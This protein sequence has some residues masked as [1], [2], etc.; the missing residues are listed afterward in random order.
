MPETA[1]ELYYHISTY[2][3]NQK[4]LLQTPAPLSKHSRPETEGAKMLI[5]AVLHE[6]RKV[7]SEM[8]SKAILRAFRIPV[9]QTMVAHTPTESLLLAE[10]I[11]FPIAMKIDSPDIVHKSE[12][13]G[14]RL[15]ITNAPAVRNA[16]HDIIETVKKRHPTARINGV[17]IE[18][19]LARPNGRELMIGV[20]RDPI[21][22]PIITFGA[23]GT[24]VEVFSDRAVALPPLNRFLAR[25]LIRSTRASK[26]LGEFRNMPPVNLEALEDV[27]LHVSQM[28]CELPWLQELDLNPLI[29][30]E[31]GAIAADARIV[32]DYAAPS[33][34]RYAH[35]AIHPYPVHLIQEWELPD[36]RTVTIRPIRPEDAEREQQFVIGLSD[37]SKYYRFMDTIRELTQTM[38]VRF[39][40]I[41]YDREMALVATLPDAD[42]KEV[43]IAVARYVTNPD[44]ESVEFALAVADDWQKHGVGRKLM[45]ALIAC[46][47]AKGYRTVVGDVLSMNTKMFNLMTK[48][49]FTIHPHPDDPAVKRVIKPLNTYSAGPALGC[50]GL[51]VTPRISRRQSIAVHG[52]ERILAPIQCTTIG[53]AAP[54]QYSSSSASIDS[55]SRSL[56]GISSMALRKSRATEP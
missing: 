16:Y 23:G 37:E 46:A 4:L 13:G 29:V 14:V 1:V 35:M 54:A 53:R 3:W 28:I 26:L 47:R 51:F 55:S 12:V 24:E 39:T 17:S 22:G 2:Y 15:N 38:L 30:D 8:E 20:S 9:A 43:Q 33:G 50:S 41:D 19:Y 21:F 42:G 48:L 6:R 49:G 44:G 45:S 18:P 40:Q 10:Q 11:G 52:R 56:S 7:L 31:N 27:L 32:I 5:E 25:D 34:D 36:G